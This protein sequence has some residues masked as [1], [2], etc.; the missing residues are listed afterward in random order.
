M[1]RFCPYK[2]SYT[3]LVPIPRVTLRSALSYVLLRPF[4]SAVGWTG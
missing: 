2:A 4:R 1:I 3:R